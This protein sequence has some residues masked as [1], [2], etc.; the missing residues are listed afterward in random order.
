VIGITQYLGLKKKESV[1]M[2]KDIKVTV[3]LN[4]KKVD[5]GVLG[6]G[7]TYTPARAVAEAFGATVSYDAVSKTVNITK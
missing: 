2:D 1:V 5:D 3:N 6:N 7:T 4:A